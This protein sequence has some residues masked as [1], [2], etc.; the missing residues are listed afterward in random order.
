MKST[1]VTFAFAIA[2]AC[3]PSAAIGQQAAV[4]GTAEWSMPA[5][6]KAVQAQA[7]RSARRLLLA[8][9]DSMPERLYRDKATPAQRDFAQQ[10]GFAAH[11]AYR[12]G[13]FS[14]GIP[15]P[16]D[17]GDTVAA[18]GS[19]VG[20][21]R[22]INVIYDRLDAWLVEQ[23][24]VSRNQRIDFF[25]N[26]IPRWLA[27]DEISAFTIWI[28]G[29]IVANFRKNGMAPPGYRFFEPT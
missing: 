13:A 3:G 12:I 28:E 18:Y 11:E 22:Y 27:W 2:T 20:L 8:M 1:K 4:K 26:E 19:R 16:P 15:S 5:E 29:Q 7:L 21:R 10:V 24:S 9:A 17:A 14:A 25:G 23:S 6:Y